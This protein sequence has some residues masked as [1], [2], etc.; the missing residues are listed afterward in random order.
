MLFANLSILKHHPMLAVCNCC[1]V[2]VN[3]EVK[4]L[5]EYKLALNSQRNTFG[6]VHVPL[7]SVAFGSIVLYEPVTF[8]TNLIL[9]LSCLLFAR[10]LQRMPNQDERTK[11]FYWFFTAMSFSFLMGGLAHLLYDYFD[12]YAWRRPSFIF[13]GLAVFA[14]QMSVRGQFPASSRKVLSLFFSFEFLVYTW[15]ILFKCDFL[16]LKI[17]STFGITVFVIGSQ[18]YSFYKEKDRRGLYIAAGLVLNILALPI[19]GF[20]LHLHPVYFNHNDLAHLLMMFCF[21][22]MFMGARGLNLPKLIRVKA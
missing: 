7:H 17:N 8:L 10:Q 14:A 2:D 11:G 12:F 13:T 18:L 22:L 6:A 1:N 15:F 4:F 21:Y 5:G 9:T 3:C 16:W 20:K 19:H